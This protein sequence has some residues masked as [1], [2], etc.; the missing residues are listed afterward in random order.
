MLKN[1]RQILTV[2][3]CIA[4]SIVA[5]ACSQG[6]QKAAEVKGQS[7]TKSSQEQGKAT[8]KALSLG[9]SSVGSTY[10]VISVGMGEIISKKTGIGVT[11]E[12]VGG[13]DANVRGLKDK[14]IDLAMLNASSVESAY[15]G[16]D[17]FAKEGRVQLRALMQ[18]QE[19]L[20]NVVARKDAGI[21]TIADLKGKKFIAKRRSAVDVWQTA[22]ALLRAYG[23]RPEDVTILETTETNEATEALKLGTADAAVIQ[24]G[25]PASTLTELAQS[26]DMTFISIPD[27]KL[28]AALKQLGPAFHKSK[29]PAGT[30]KGQD[31]DVYIPALSTV[32]V[33]MAD[34]SEDTAYLITKT[35][36]ESQDDLKAVHSAGKEWNQGNTLK[37]PPVPFHPGAIKYFK[38]KGIWT[39]E[40][41]KIQKGLLGQ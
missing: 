29:I 39:P 6:G 33:T 13:S 9:T 1:L 35:L 15:N 4:V 24:G 17:Q 19:S 20:R 16:K 5:V 10:Y 34:F 32:I 27:D 12:A 21:K 31:Q 26:K 30:Y 38:E 36:M 7:E 3:L 23:V 41:E 2:V 11:A 14:K 28:E 25:V 18:G 8:P 22:E 37:A 40:L